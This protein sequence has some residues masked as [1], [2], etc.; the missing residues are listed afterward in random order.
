MNRLIAVAVANQMHAEPRPIAEAAD[1]RSMRRAAP[2][3]IGRQNAD[4]P[5]PDQGAQERQQDPVAR[6]VVAAEPEV[7]PGDQA[8]VR[9]QARAKHL[10][11]VVRAVGLDDQVRDAEGSRDQPRLA[12]AAERLSRAQAVAGRQ[13]QT[14]G[15][16]R[17]RI[18]MAV[19]ADSAATSRPK[20]PS[21]QKWFAVTITTQNTRTG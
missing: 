17:A 8:L 5:R 4:Q 14:A 19:T 1:R 2:P 16:T 18:C 9:E 10:G 15:R 13:D 3:T 11:G 21:T 20:A 6:Q 7:V 12:V